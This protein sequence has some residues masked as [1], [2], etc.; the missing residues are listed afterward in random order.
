MKLIFSLFSLDIVLNNENA[1]FGLLLIN[2]ESGAS[3]TRSDYLLPGRYTIPR[4]LIDLPRTRMMAM[5]GFFENSNLIV[6]CGGYSSNMIPKTFAN[7][8][9]TI[10]VNLSV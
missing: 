5:G 1:D 7:E 2:N 6:L 4:I 3:K 8:G 10:E 9:T